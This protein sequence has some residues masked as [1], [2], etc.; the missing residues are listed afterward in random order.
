MKRITLLLTAFIVLSACQEKKVET[1]ED[2]IAP[3]ENMTHDELMET[4]VIKE[5]DIQKIGILV[6]DGVND[7][8]ALGP[9][10]VFKN[11]MGVEV[12]TIAMQ[13]GNVTTV[14]G[15]E[16][17]PDTIT[18]KVDSLDILV[19]PGGFKETI[20]NAY[21]EELLQWIREIDKTTQYTTSVCTGGWILGRT[22]LLEGRK[23][24]GNWFRAQ[25]I[26][27]ENGASF[28]GERY[29]R[30]G[31]Y[32]TSAGVTA[33]MDMSLAILTELTGEDYAQ[34][35]MLDM[36]YDPAPPISGG[37]VAKTKP[38]VLQFMQT[39][40]ASMADPIFEAAKNGDNTITNDTQ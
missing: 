4:V 39:M 13:P 23:A 29:T 2:K 1:A 12:F 15:L 5:H 20:E 30:D 34:A 11:I 14:M 27:A 31:K 33:G 22:G 18:E 17:I 10:Y 36:E 9:R 38:E 24:T 3:T 25:K 7:L 32:W 26:L 21:N 8:D 6:Y 37:S 16:F 28:T 40:Y 19:V 35:V